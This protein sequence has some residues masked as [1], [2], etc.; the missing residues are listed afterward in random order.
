MDEQQKDDS[1]S[2]E[3]DALHTQVT[4]S[5]DTK[6]GWVSEFVDELRLIPEVH[7]YFIVAKRELEI[8]VDMESD[9]Y[10]GRSPHSPHSFCHGWIVR[11]IVEYI[12]RTLVNNGG[13]FVVWDQI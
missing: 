11:G 5:E 13:Y 3:K 10:H 9:Y 8:F 6:I 12:N 1:M 7:P 2:Y 4:L